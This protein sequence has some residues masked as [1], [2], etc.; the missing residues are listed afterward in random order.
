MRSWRE[1]PPLTRKARVNGNSYNYAADTTGE[2]PP[3]EERASEHKTPVEVENRLA[4]MR[5]QGPGDSS[6]NATQTSVIP[7]LLWRG[8]H[9]N[10]VVEQV[11]DA[12][13]AMAEAVWA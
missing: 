9:P 4:V 3:V 5:W 11:V 2:N 8:I 6:V 7:A 13:M 12:T 1:P 10:D